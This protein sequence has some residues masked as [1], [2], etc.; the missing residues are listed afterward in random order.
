MLLGWL[1]AF[2]VTQAVE[3]PIYARALRGR[4]AV[5]F[6]ASL[7]THPV[8]WF[9]FPVW[10]RSL[11]YARHVALAEAFAVAVEALWLSRFGVRRS[12]WWALAANA[13]SVAVGLT[14]RWLWGWP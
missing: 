14:S 12:V 11:G 5:A 13:A 2:A 10:F 9:G 8:V 7:L 4:W 6:G 3:V 1:G